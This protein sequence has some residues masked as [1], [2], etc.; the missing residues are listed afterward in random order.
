MAWKNFLCVASLSK[1]FTPYVKWS[2][3]SVVLPL[4][5][6]QRG[7]IIVFRPSGPC[8]VPWCLQLR[9]LYENNV[10]WLFLNCEMSYHSVLLMIRT[11]STMRQ[12]YCV[13]WLCKTG[14]G[15]YYV[16]SFIWLREFLSQKYYAAVHRKTTGVTLFRSE[17]DE[18]ST[19]IMSSRDFHTNPRN[20]C[21]HIWPSTW[22]ISKKSLFML[23][24][25]TTET[26]DRFLY[27]QGPY[28]RETY[29]PSNLL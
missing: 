9:S 27:Y 29:I 24:L 18:G 5:F 15:W 16:I 26:A 13:W 11:S 4:A 20:V 7:S 23:P 25:V 17:K 3:S 19:Q 28:L 12:K 21:R 22:T 6:F 2:S 1:S 8:L 10:V 14:V